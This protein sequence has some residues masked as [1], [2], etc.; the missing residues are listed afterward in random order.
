MRFG[1]DPDGLTDRYYRWIGTLVGVLMGLGAPVGHLALRLITQGHI[2]PKWL[3][4]EMQQ[5]WQAYSY[6]FFAS[7]AMFMVFG[8]ALGKL[9]DKIALQRAE[10]E[11]LN[12]VLEN[13]SIT[14][15]LTGLYNHRHIL[16][17]TDKEIERAKRYGRQLSGIMID[18]DDFKSI[19]DLYGHLT[20]DSVLRQLAEVLKRSVRNVDIVGRFGGDEFVVL[21]PEA[22]ND[23]AR[24]VAERILQSVRQYPFK[25]ARDYVS[26]TVTLGVFSTQGGKDL[27]RSIFLDRIDRAMFRAKEE[28]KNRIH[29]GS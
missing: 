21:L 27:D 15:D 13:Q 28:G 4:S 6:L 20:G 12:L 10:L 1:R 18:S 24:A 16:L 5:E 8:Y 9:A 22:S 29:Y 11:K 25:T 19:N 23:A 3:K 7:L 26:M 17:L 14:D 2:S